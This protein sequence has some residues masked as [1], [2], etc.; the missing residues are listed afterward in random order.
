MR[1]VVSLPTAPF[2]EAGVIAYVRAFTSNRKHVTVKCDTHGNVVAHY[3][4]GNGRIARPICLAAHMDHPGFR[5]ERMAS[6]GVVHAIWHGGVMPEYVRTAGVRFFTG[7]KWVKGRVTGV[8]TG[9]RGTQ[10]VV[11]SAEIAVGGNIEPGSPGMWDFPDT[12]VRGGRIVGRAC[13]DL[14]GVAAMLACLDDV[15]ARGATG[16]AY[17]LF[18]RAEEVGF[19]GAMA[20]CKANSIPR[21]CLLAAVENSAERVNAKQGDGPILRVG[22]RATTF[23]SPA[24]QFCELV[25]KDLTASDKSFRYQRR[26]MDGGMCESSAY[27]GLG[28]DA[29]GLCIALG[30]YHNMNTRTKKLGAEYVNVEDWLSLVR[31][32]TAL[33]TTK[34]RYDGRD[35]ALDEKLDRLQ[36]EYNPIL[37]RTQPMVTA[38]FQ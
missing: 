28:Y 36:K 25:A 35:T 19:V 9:K 38:G 8:E 23:T 22:D 33:V 32:F 7:G 34:R 6:G 5:A 13:D 21:R 15:S 30:N 12:D 17:F 4:K 27:C 29:T 26:L 14:A 16:E 37:K 2:A 1:E 3:R 18:T 20:A 10:T 24:T 31:W 11:K